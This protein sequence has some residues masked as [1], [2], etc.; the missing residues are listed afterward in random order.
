M[1]SEAKNLR[2][3]LRTGTLGSTKV[4]KSRLV[5]YNGIEIEIKEPSVAGW[6]A[7]LSNA[8]KNENINFSEFLIWSVIYCAFVPGTDQR[9]YEE[10][11]YTALKEQPKSGFVGEFAEIANDLIAVAPKQNLKNS[12]AMGESRES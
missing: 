5:E 7:I 1:S 11:D 2:D 4:F 8:M 10:G 6:G 12:E 9:V 3:Q